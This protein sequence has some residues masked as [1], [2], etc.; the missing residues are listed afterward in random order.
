MKRAS[1]RGIGFGRART[2]KEGQ[3]G[4]TKCQQ[5]RDQKR[6]RKRKDVHLERR[7]TTLAVRNAGR[8]TTEKEA[9]LFVESQ[10]T[11]P[12]AC[13]AVTVPSCKE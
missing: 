4:H 13:H 7:A 11:H 3:K 2:A 10:I 8:S 5:L 1:D 9:G 12:E 6:E